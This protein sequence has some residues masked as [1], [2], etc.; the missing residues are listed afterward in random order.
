[1]PEEFR[2]P[3]DHLRFLKPV[4]AGLNIV[5]LASM[6]PLLRNTTL[7]HDPVLVGPACES[8][9]T[10]TVLDG[11]HRVIASIAAGRQDVLA[12]EEG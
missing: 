9:G 4:T 12:M 5:T 11:R 3:L 2:V 8:C 7:D 10:R 1:M 6:I